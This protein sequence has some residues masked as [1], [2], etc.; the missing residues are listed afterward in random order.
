MTMSIVIGVLLLALAMRL[1]IP[2]KRAKQT[3]DG[4]S[5]EPYRIYTNQFDLT[6]RADEIPV[7][8]HAESPD[9]EKGWSD[10]TGSGW[11]QAE[12]LADGL[13]TPEA[14]QTLLMDEMTTWRS[15][16]TEAADRQTTLI[17][18]LVDQSGS[19]RGMPLAAVRSAL[20][21]VSRLLDGDGIATEILGFSTVGWHGGKAYRHW[22]KA[23]RPSRPGRLCALLHIVYKSA[24]ERFWNETSKRAMLHPDIARENID[25]EA[26]QWAVGRLSNHPA[27]RK[28]LIVISDGASVDDATIMH[29]GPS[30]L[31]R[32]IRRVIADIEARND[33]ALGAIGVN[34]D[35]SGYYRN[36]VSPPLEELA[37]ATIR[38]IVQLADH[39]VRPGMPHA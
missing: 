7:R 27:S 19:M 12:E 37:L 39:N 10:L 21:S 17:T 11:K 2:G 3:P 31:D 25:G 1:A 13:H 4:P 9:A 32:D 29:N 20:D 24:D 6:L 14:V 34:Y 35:V 33:I 26:L 28:M 36:A 15:A 8:L 23:G 5:D 30:Y 22:L 16:K 18:F 38:I